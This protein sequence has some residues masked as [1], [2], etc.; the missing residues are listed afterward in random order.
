ME[1][2]LSNGEKRGSECSTSMCMPNPSTLYAPY[3]NV[4]H[5]K[6]IDMV[7]ASSSPSCCP[8]SYLTLTTLV[9]EFWKQESDIVV[10]K[11]LI[12][13]SDTSF[14]SEKKF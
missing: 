7:I 1:S 3:G 13:T 5:N 9:T 10:G 12:P 11:W 6:L 14:A 2:V 4:K 8:T